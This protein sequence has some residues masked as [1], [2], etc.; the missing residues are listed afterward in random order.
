VAC[1]CGVLLVETDRALIDSHV[2]LL[3]S[4][5]AHFSGAA[6]DAPPR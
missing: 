2:R 1:L 5:S 4:A 3:M 6:L